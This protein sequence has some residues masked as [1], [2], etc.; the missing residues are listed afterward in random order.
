MVYK[1]KAIV[2]WDPVDQ[3]VLANEQV[4]EGCGWRSGVPV[5]KKEIS[6]WYMKITDYADEL[7]ADIQ[8][9]DGWP[10]AVRMMQTNWI[11]KSVGLDINFKIDESR[12]LMVYTTRPDTLFGVTYLAI[13]AEHPIA[14][15][16]GKTK[17]PYL[18]VRLLLKDKYESNNK[19]KNINSPVL[20]MHGKLDNIVPFY[21]GQK[22]YELANKPK[23]YYFTE[24][25]DHMMEYDEN[26]LKTLKDF[27]NSLN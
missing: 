18:P 4:V 27:I 21:M 14:I 20:I 26:L 17:Y 8:K 11:G 22:M 3:T 10:D 13:A 7:L 9:L 5:E 6:Q 25:D 23:Y 24:Y 16:A 19:I 1:K 2:N 12:S 15:E